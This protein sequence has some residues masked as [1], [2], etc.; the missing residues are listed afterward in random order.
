MVTIHDINIRLEPILDLVMTL[1]MITQKNVIPNWYDQF[2]TTCK[3]FITLSGLTYELEG[4]FIGMHHC[5]ELLI[6]PDSLRLE[7]V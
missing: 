1:Q 7:T 2:F 6:Q 3:V 5:T 4:L